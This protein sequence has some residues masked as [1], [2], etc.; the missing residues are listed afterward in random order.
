MVL[1]SHCCMNCI[2][3]TYFSLQYVNLYFFLKLLL[4]P[5]E[6][7]VDFCLTL[8]KSHEE[9]FT[10]TMQRKKKRSQMWP[11]LDDIYAMILI[12]KNL[13]D[14]D[15]L[16]ELHRLEYNKFFMSWTSMFNEAMFQEIASKRSLI[17]Y[18]CSWHDK[19]IILRTV[20]IQA[21]IFLRLQVR[22]T[23]KFFFMEFSKKNNL[24]EVVKVCVTFIRLQ[25]YLILTSE[26]LCVWTALRKNFR[27]RLYTH[28]QYFCDYF[29]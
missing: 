16:Y 14:K 11:L 4:Y 28:Q 18:T 13:W 2:F 6:I 22:T 21:K 24:M 19:L 12:F 25:L 15:E 7:T 8:F 10:R 20:K 1:E 27:T 5:Q 26:K 29:L 23:K 9:A 3:H 17:K